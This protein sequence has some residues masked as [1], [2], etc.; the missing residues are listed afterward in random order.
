M[1]MK[2][3]SKTIFNYLKEHV[4]EDLTANDVAE[5]LGMD[6]RS[7]NGTFT[8]LQKKGYGVREEAEIEYDDGT[9]KKVKYLRLTED[10]MAYNPD[11]DTASK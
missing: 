5:V 1:A 10:G 7:V 2:E 11:E 6:P 8:A 9:H 4:G 3:N